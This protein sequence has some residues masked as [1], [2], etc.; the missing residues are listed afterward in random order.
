METEQETPMAEELR[1]NASSS[2]GSK[3]HGI[4]SK[5]SDVS[6]LCLSRQE[7]DPDRM[8][9]EA[10]QDEETPK[11]LLLPSVSV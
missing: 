3:G 1:P 7:A 8:E 9:M 4:R 10:E 6:F 5:L 11:A 2:S